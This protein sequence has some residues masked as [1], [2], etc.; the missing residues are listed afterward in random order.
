MPGLGSLKSPCHG[1]QTSSGN[2]FRLKET[3]ETCQL[4][5][6]HDPWLDLESEL[7]KTAKRTLLE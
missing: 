2:C 4:N 7:W 6:T 3:K 5:T 1:K